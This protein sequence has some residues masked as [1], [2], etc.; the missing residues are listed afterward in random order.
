[1]QALTSPRSR[2]RV[3]EMDNLDRALTSWRVPEPPG[4]LKE[5]GVNHYQLQTIR[6]LAAKRLAEASSTESSRTIENTIADWLYDLVRRNVKR[7]RVFELDEVLA[8][9]R[10]DCLGYARLFAALGPR[11]GLELG[12]VEVVVDNAGRSVPHHVNLLNLSN[13]TRRFIDAWYGSKDIRHRRMGALVDGRA[14]D[15]DQG[16]L[17]EVRELRGLPE[18]C[19]DAIT[20]YI[21]GNGHLERGELDEAIRCYTRAIALYPNNTRAFYNRALAH[22]RRGEAEEAALDYAEALKDESS[23][24]RLLAS[25]EGIEGLL[26]L[27]EAGVSEEEQDIYLWHRGFK[28]GEEVACEELG[29]RYGIAPEEIAKTVSK[30]ETLCRIR[31]AKEP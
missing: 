19:V 1:M 7:G 8:S 18:Q 21:K 22:D 4:E 13:G 10:A 27:D 17:G 2:V 12:V 23:T 14:R 25:I 30:V 26:E 9:R 5:A 24:V 28:T 16:E 31:E 11:F 20:L 6:A 3:V 29:C 15:I